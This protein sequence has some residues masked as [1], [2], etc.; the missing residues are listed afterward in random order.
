MINKLSKDLQK[1]KSKI[2][3]KDYFY[4]IDELLKNTSFAI[5]RAGAGSIIDL[6]NYKIPSILIPLPNSKDNHQFHNALY[7]KK[8]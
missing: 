4:N 2:I 7:F 8:T 6:I 5:S 3:I 1:C